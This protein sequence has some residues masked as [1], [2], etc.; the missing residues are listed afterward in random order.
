[1]SDPNW[2]GARVLVT[3]A[4]G[5]IGSHLCRY[6]VARG[7]SV[8]GVSRRIPADQPPGMEWSDVHLSD[9]AAVGRLYSLVAP[10]IVFH[11]AGHVSGSRLI[12][13]VQPTLW[14]NFVSTVHLLT[15]VAETGKGRILLAGSMEEPEFG[16][17]NSSVPSSPYA[18]SKWACSAYARMF[19][20]L[21][22][23]SVVIARPMMVYGPGQWESAKLLPY[24]ILSLLKGERPKLSSGTREIDWVYVHDVVEGIARIAASSHLD[25]QSIDLGSG[26][27][28]S[29]RHLVEELVLIT[30]FRGPVD[31]GDLP[32]RPFEVSRVARVDETMRLIGWV[33]STPLREGLT[34]TVA[35]Y[36]TRSQ[37]LG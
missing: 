7:A 12:E 27:P 18:A 24:L 9:L 28:T 16:D 37:E 3:G 13:N 11:L 29:I 26:I 22:G 20:A 30:G 8:H 6:L 25:G 33:P 35:W 17:L 14:T 36:R 21:Y 10:D 1:M 32:D 31:F 34:K 2:R 5:F 19:H 4:R 15:I 23:V